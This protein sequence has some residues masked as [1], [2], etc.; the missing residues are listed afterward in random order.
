MIQKIFQ[1]MTR[2]SRAVLDAAQGSATA[3]RAFDALGLSAETLL[4]QGTDEAFESIA[5]AISRVED[6]T[7]RLGLASQVLGRSGADLMN[8]LNLGPE[9]MAELARQTTVAGTASCATGNGSR[10]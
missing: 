3:A 10:S 5:A 1:A 7:L 2:S 8:F 6:P 4:G 9:G